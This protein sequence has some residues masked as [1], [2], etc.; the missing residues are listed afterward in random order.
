[1]RNRK[2]KYRNE[3]NNGQK[4]NELSKKIYTNL[5]SPAFFCLKFLLC[6]EIIMV[7]NYEEMFVLDTDT[8]TLK[9][10]HFPVRR[11]GG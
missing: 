1:M 4:V 6:T 7:F 11:V 3:R 10:S 5:K 8:N 2:I 9:P